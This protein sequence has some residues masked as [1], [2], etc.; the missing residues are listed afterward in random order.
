MKH[1]ACNNCGYRNS[2]AN[3]SCEKCGSFLHGEEWP[4]RNISIERD[5]S[6]RDRIHLDSEESIIAEFAPDRKIENVLM[7]HAFYSVMGVSLFGGFIAIASEITGVNST[8]SL[9]LI[10]ITFA[11]GFGIPAVMTLHS[12]TSYYRKVFSD[13]RYMITNKRVVLREVTR[14]LKPGIVTFP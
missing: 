12:A 1:I 6:V 14:K 11:V 9:A 13:T 7:R 3:A 2:F 5:D 8:P 10:L 4:K